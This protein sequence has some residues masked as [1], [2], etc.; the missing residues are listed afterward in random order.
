MSKPFQIALMQAQDLPVASSGTVPEWI[1]L[2]PAGAEV[3]TADGRGPYRVNDPQEIVAAAVGKKLPLDENHSIDLAAR[4]GGEARARGY[5][6]ELQAREDGIW[7]R[8]DWNESGRALMSDRAYVGVSPAVM[9]DGQKRII[10]IA[11][12]SL[13]NKPNL[14]GLTAL[15]MENDMDMS[16]VAKA[17]GL[18][19]DASLETILAAIAGMKTPD[20]EKVDLQSQLGQIGVALGVTAGA[21]P[22]VILTAAKTAVQADD[23][24]VIVALQS[25]LSQITTQLNTLT[26]T[27]AKSRAEVFVDGEIKRGRVGVK[28]LRDHYISMHMQ[29]ASRVE[30][31][32]TALPVLG[33]GNTIVPTQIAKEGQISLHSEQLAA[34]KALGLD[35]KSYA[36]S[37]KAENEEIL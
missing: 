3:M 1:H 30:K 14:R 26:E 2:L 20:A 24:K 37:L 15:H 36:A 29:D 22:E 32:I 31:E 12:A 5:I 18:A 9:H 10:G 27:G 11:R 28:P 4:N 19:E 7:G 17:L 6:V 25:E 23:K 33:S 13:T 16:A 35:P 8:M 21:T 34:A